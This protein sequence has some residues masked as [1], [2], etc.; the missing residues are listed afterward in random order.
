MFDMIF[1][2]KIKLKKKKSLRKENLI[3]KHGLKI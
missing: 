3:Q 1:T 2:H